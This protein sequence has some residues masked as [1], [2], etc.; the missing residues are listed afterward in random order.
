MPRLPG[1]AVSCGIGVELWLVADMSQGIV[2]ELEAER[3]G[4]PL[5]SLLRDDGSLLPRR[6][7]V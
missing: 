4:H 2:P 3:A 5:L 7:R 6:G 1:L